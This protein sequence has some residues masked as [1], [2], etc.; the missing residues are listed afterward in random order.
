MRSS[1]KPLLAAYCSLSI[2]H[3]PPAHLIGLEVHVVVADLKQDADEVDEWDV[4]AGSLAF[5]EIDTRTDR[6]AATRT[7]RS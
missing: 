5:V 6:P 4:V 1:A 7:V 3:E 2:A